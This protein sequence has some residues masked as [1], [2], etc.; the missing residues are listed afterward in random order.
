MDAVETELR[1]VAIRQDRPVMNRVETN[2]AVW[3]IVCLGKMSPNDRC[4]RRRPLLFLLLRPS[5]LHLALPGE[6]HY[7]ILTR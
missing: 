2:E 6:R 3:L 1:M 7:R 4:S 5:C